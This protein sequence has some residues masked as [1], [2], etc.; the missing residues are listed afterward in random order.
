MDH[1]GTGAAIIHGSKS[2]R[3]DAPAP[4]LPGETLDPELVALPAPRKSLTKCGARTEVPAGHPWQAPNPVAC[5]APSRPGWN[6]V[7]GN[8]ENLPRTSGIW[9]G[10]RS[11]Q[12][13]VS[14]VP[15]RG[16]AAV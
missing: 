14:T 3:D 5:R 11:F 4:R 6:F 12:T 10:S 7:A 9:A 2:R 15:D 8:L 13:H 1:C 16:R